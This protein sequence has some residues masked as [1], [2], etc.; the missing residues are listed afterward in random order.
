MIIYSCKKS[1]DLISEAI[2]IEDLKKEN[3]TENE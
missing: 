2:T 1:Y 3:I